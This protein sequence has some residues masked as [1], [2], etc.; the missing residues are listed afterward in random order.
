ME[1][2]EL[3]IELYEVNPEYIDYLVPYAHIYFIIRSQSNR[4]SGNILVL[5]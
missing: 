2:R 4:M 5:F 1:D 3:A